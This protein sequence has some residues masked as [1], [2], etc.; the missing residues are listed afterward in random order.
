MNGRIESRVVHQFGNPAA[1]VQT[2]EEH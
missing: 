2:R 1:C